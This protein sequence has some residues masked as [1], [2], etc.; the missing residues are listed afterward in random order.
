MARGGGAGRRRER[1]RRRAR[2]T[3]PKIVLSVGCI[4][5]S[6]ALRGT[7]LRVRVSEARAGEGRT[8]VEL[9]RGIGRAGRQGRGGEADGENPHRNTELLEH[10]LDGR[11]RRCVGWPK[12]GGNG[13]GS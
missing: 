13:G 12:R 5:R 1:R 10:L 9:R 7:H 4:G 2:R 6:W 3:W 11:E 8:A